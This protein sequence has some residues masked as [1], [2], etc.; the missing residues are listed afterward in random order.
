MSDA[1]TKNYANMPADKFREKPE[2]IIWLSKE[3]LPF[4]IK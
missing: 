3:I 2:T 4:S 1:N